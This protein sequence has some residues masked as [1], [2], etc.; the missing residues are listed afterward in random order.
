MTEI[1][2][3]LSKRFDVK[4]MGELHYFLRVNITQ[5]QKGDVWIGQLVYTQD[6]LTKFGMSEAKPVSTPVDTGTKLVK[7]MDDSSEVDQGLY[8]SAVGSLL[9][10]S[11][12]PRPDIAYAVSIVAQ[13]SAKPTK[14]HWT[15]V[16]R[17]LRYLQGTKNF[18]L[19]YSK[20]GSKE[21]VGYSDVDWAGDLDN[22]RSTSGYVF[23]ISG[24]A[25]SWRS[26]K[27]TCV[28]LSTTEAEYMALANATQEA[29]WMQQLTTDLKN[30][31][32]KPII[33]FED[34]QSAIYIAKNPQFHGRTKHI[35]IKYHFT[36][37]QVKKGII[38]LQYCRTE[39]MIADMFTKALLKEKFI[40]LR[41]M[42][43]IKSAS[44]TFCE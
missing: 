11:S 16:K 19:L 9:Y 17:I 25:V 37:E 26:K 33:L 2:R 23:K 1:K 22:R 35:E 32:D 44:L 29:I 39:D 28:A 21:C 27:E 15:A 4:D 43:G 14:Q 13:F 12:R 34:N 7:A 40:K 42:A 24:A 8:Q 20:E 36:R 6:I 10:L 18:G 30:R 38:D 31:A 3:A 41:D 5:N